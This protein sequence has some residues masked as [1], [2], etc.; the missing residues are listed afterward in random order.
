M[1]LHKSELMTGGGPTETVLWTNPNP[2]QS[3]S[4]T[5]ITLSDDYTNYNYIG[6]T[7]KKKNSDSNILQKVFISTEYATKTGMMYAF[8]SRIYIRS[9]NLNDSN[10]MTIGAGMSTSSSA[11]SA[12]LAAHAIPVQVIGL[13]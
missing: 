10:K 6:L 11:T 8:D 3:W 7:Y 13:I 5:T 1:A 9:F 2:S 12:D 4:A